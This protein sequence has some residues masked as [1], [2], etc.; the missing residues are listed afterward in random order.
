MFK[1]LL[2][3]GN[4]FLGRSILN[5]NIFKKYII[6]APNRQDLNLTNKKHVENFFQKNQVA[7]IINCAIKGG[8]R[9]KKET[10]QDFYDNIISLS[11]VLE[12]I[13][14]DIKLIT[15]S[16]GAEKYKLDTFY[17]SS[18]KI[19]TSLVRD[20]DYV[21]NIRIY[22]IFGEQ[23]MKDSFVYSTIEKCIKNENIVIWEDLLFDTFYI[24]DL[25]NMINLL[26][27]NNSKNYQEIECVYQ[28]KYKLSDIAKIIKKIC[29]S[30]SNIIIEKD[31][32]LKYIG[33]YKPILNL[34]ACFL[35]KS[36]KDFIK[37]KIN[38]LN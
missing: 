36:I 7:W 4:G 1:I 18:K 3:G 28:Q 24:K 37:V 23:G 19:C 38:H 9:T 15:F 16:S 8:R 5:S 20:K 2:T 12:Y 11:N 33:D 17:G 22:N 14:K 6:L 29:N 35:E 25:I 26:I 27:E 10:S 34:D 32:N 30:K 13:S 21:T 31:N